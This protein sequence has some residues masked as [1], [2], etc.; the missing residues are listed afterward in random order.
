MKGWRLALIPE[1]IFCFLSRGRESGNYYLVLHSSAKQYKDSFLG[2]YPKPNNW[3]F[4]FIK[5]YK[6]KKAGDISIILRTPRHKDL[7]GLQD[8]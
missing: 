6:D 8:L 2:L 5:P 3:Y 4:D 7:S 1:I